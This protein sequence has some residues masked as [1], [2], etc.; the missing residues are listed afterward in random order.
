MAGCRAR[1]DDQRPA[2]GHERPG[3]GG[4][5]PGGDSALIQDE[6]MVDSKKLYSN[7]EFESSIEDVK[8]FIEARQAYLLSRP[9]LN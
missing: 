5:L 9:E 4:G 8:Q 7:A 2:A 1:R 3:A 6:V